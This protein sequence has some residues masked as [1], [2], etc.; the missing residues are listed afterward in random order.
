MRDCFPVGR[1]DENTFYCVSPNYMG[2]SQAIVGMARAKLQ[3]NLVIRTY[4]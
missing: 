3:T 2:L 1:N 4:A